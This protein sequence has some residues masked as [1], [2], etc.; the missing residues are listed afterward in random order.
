MEVVAVEVDFGQLSVAD[1][2]PGG[3][4]VVVQAGVDLQAGA[5]GG[6]GDQV[7]D[8][9]VVDQ[10]TAPAWHCSADRNAETGHCTA[11]EH[12]FSHDR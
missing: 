7:D 9:G 3:V 10:L 5:G 12:Q 8:G 11:V 6:A 4:D 1:L 2:D